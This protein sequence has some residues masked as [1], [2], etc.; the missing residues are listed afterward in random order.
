M[1]EKTFAEEIEELAGGAG[2]IRAVVIGDFNV[3]DRKIPECH[4][5][6]ILEWYVARSHLDYNYGDGYGGED[7]HPVYIWTKDLIIVVGRYDGSTWLREIPRNPQS[8][9]PDFIG[10]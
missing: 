10:G 5:N 4:T 3:E 1:T 9:S 7:C 2:K 8:C 6:C